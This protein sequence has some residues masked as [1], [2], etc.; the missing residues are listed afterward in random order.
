MGGAAFHIASVQPGPT[1][2]QGTSWIGSSVLCAT[3]CAVGDACDE[4]RGA[5]VLLPAPGSADDEHP[6]NTTAAAA[7]TAALRKVFSMGIPFQSRK[8]ALETLKDS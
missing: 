4:V 3:G 8:G 7:K 5:C 6:A 1:C 2:D